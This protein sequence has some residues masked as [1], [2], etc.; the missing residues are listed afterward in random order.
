MQ[1]ASTGNVQPQQTY[2]QSVSDYHMLA[3]LA[4][5]LSR[6]QL[7]YVFVR[8]QQ[9]WLAASLQQQ[10]ELMDM[11]I[12]VA[13]DSPRADPMTDNVLNFLWDVYRT[14]EGPRDMAEKARVTHLHILSIWRK[15]IHNRDSLKMSWLKKC[16]EEIE[17]GGCLVSALRLF[18]GI[19]DQFSQVCTDLFTNVK[20]SKPSSEIVVS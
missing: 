2:V 1:D 17:R 6:E 9:S 18:R 3:R 19:C 4:W 11:I 15:S 10:S 13:E 16:L 8:F 14:K 5:D 7:N 12:R 20:R